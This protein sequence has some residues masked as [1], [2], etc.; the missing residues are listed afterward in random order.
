MASVA[1]RGRNMFRKHPSDA[2]DCAGD[3]LAKAAFPEVAR[4]LRGDRIPGALLHSGVNSLVGDDLERPLGEEE[5]NQ[6]SRPSRRPVH[7]QPAEF[8]QGEVMERQRAFLPAAAVPHDD[9]NFTGGLRFRR[10]YALREEL[11]V[12]FGQMVSHEFYQLPLA[13]PPPKPPPPPPPPRLPPPPLKPPPPPPD[14]PP[15]TPPP[16]PNPPNQKP[17]ERYPRDPT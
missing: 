9:P 15:P 2:V 7:Q 5:K 16:P 8:S 3:S 4:H 11:Q 17:P 14:P 10:G 1:G 6:N 12:V 13:P